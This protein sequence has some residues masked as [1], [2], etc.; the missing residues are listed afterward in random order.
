MHL[1]LFFACL[2]VAE[3]ETLRL[4]PATGRSSASM[5]ANVSAKDATVAGAELSSKEDDSVPP[6]IP[7]PPCEQDVP[8]VPDLPASTG[9]PKK[10]VRTTPADRMLEEY[11]NRVLHQAPVLPP[12]PPP[13]DEKG[14]YGQYICAEMQKMTDNQFTT[15]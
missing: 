12:P 2:L 9:K 7:S 14:I 1:C 11:M 13:T 5:T 8:D 4:C 10:R 15:F 3:E 6:T